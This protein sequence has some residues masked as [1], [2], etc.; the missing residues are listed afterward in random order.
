MEDTKA[1][2]ETFRR[3]GEEGVHLSIDDFGTGYS[4]LSY[5]RRLPAAELKID[6]S[7]V[8]D[9][10]SSSDARAVVDAVVRLAHALGLKVVAEGVENQRQQDILVE[11]GCDELQGY[12]FSKPISA[13]ALLLWA[14]DDQAATAVFKP[15]LFGETEVNTLAD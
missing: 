13:R 10:E 14:M 3:F 8:M 7:F 1:I 12:H 9:L 6:S 2:Q 11:L 15:S 5:L 4:S